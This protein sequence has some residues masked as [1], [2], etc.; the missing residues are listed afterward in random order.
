MSVEDNGDDDDYRDDSKIPKD[1]QTESVSVT[2][3]F[4]F[5]TDCKDRRTYSC[6]KERRKES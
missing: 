5:P 2:K 1:I 6:G 3:C 4:Y